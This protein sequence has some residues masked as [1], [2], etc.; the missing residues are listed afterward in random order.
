MSRFDH[1]WKKYFKKNTPPERYIEDYLVKLEKLDKDEFEFWRDFQKFLME[2]RE[3]RFS[4][5]QTA[6]EK[7]AKNGFNET[8]ARIVS[9][10]YNN[11]P[12]C[13]YGSI[14]E[15]GRF[16]FGA[17]PSYYTN[18][19]AL[20]MANNQPTS[21]AEKYYHLQN[22]K[23]GEGELT[24]DELSLEGTPSH[25]YVRVQVN[26][27]SYIDLRTDESL[28]GFLEAIK[29]ISPTDDLKARWKIICKRKGR[30]DQKELKTVME[31]EPLKQLIFDPNFKQWISWLDCPSHSQWLGHYAL[32]C[33][34]QG[35]VYPSVRS[36]DGYNIA[37]FPENFKESLATI[38][39]KDEVASVP[40]DR[41]QINASNYVWF[42]KPL[43]E[44]QQ[45]TLLEN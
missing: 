26:L 4:E 43:S 12:L 45:L 30:K 31:L 24:P 33:G 7:T 19:G 14:C 42:S 32:K 28:S 39:L 17:L 13:V 15:P 23:L 10:E 40:K 44:I 11:D 29:D 2:E 16:N 37:V 6:I 27:E 20:Y 3:S 22:E 35:I 21:F 34:V 41:C 25:L 1:D 18:F 9:S 5:I 8:M 38:T 36:T